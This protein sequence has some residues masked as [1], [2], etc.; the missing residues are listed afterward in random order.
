MVATDPKLVIKK[1][2]DPSSG[3]CKVQYSNLTREDDSNAHFEAS[4]K[5]SEAMLKRL[6]QKPPLFLDLIFIVSTPSEAQ[7]YSGASG[8][9][10]YN[11]TIN[12]Q[13]VTINKYN[14]DG[15]LKIDGQEL[16]T[17]ATAEIKKVIRENPLGSIRQVSGHIENVE[18]PGGLIFGDVTTVKY[19]QFASAY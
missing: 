12:I 16:N 15:S 5:H 2:L 9:V 6:M 10:Y 7:P 19:M 3:I 17:S 13:P 18:N 11:Y 14:A 8:P 4:Y 1:L